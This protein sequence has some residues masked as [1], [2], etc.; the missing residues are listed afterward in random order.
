MLLFYSSD[1]KA[2]KNDT[3]NSDFLKATILTR[4]YLDSTMVSLT[5]Q[6]DRSGGQIEDDKQRW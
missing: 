6:L 4:D 1:R 5:L 3:R 2:A